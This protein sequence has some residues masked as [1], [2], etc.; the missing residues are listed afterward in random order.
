MATFQVFSLSKK[1]INLGVSFELVRCFSDG[2]LICS[3]R[4]DAVF[5]L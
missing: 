3:E 4:K 1:Q 5:T 2:S